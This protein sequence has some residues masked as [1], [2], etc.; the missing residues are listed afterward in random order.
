MV[1][2]QVL[3]VKPPKQVQTKSTPSFVQSPPLLQGTDAHGSRFW[4]HKSPVMSGGQRQLNLLEELTQVALVAQGWLA[5]K[6]KD[7]AQRRPT[8]KPLHWQAK[9]FMRSTHCASFWQGELAHSLMLISH[10]EPVKPRRQ[11][12][13]KL[14]PLMFD[15]EGGRS[16]H[17]KVPLKKV[18]L[19]HDLF[20]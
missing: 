15:V 12:Q 20:F 16:I 2:W 6:S 7:S 1:V 10:R 17:C 18:R 13:L 4:S 3:P 8:K 5:Q 11:L 14:C 19:I 9:E